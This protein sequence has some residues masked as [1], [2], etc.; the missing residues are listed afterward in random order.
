[1]RCFVASAF[2]C[3]DVDKVYDEVVCRTLRQIGVSAVRVDRVEHN[4]DI[5]DK[6]C[7][8]IRRSDL[9]IADLTYA[10]PS[11]YYE[12]GYAFGLGK[13]VVYIVK[14]DHFRLKP[15]DGTGN[16]RVHFDLQMK[17]IIKWEPI[18]SL[19]VRLK[20]RLLHVIKPLKR[21]AKKV[22]ETQRHVSEFARLSL[23]S[24]LAEV[25]KKAKSLLFVRGFQERQHKE[26]LGL[27]KSPCEA[28]L[29]RVTNGTYQQVFLLARHG[30]TKSQLS[31]FSHYRWFLGPNKEKGVS[32]RRCSCVLLVVT[33]R[34]LRTHTL[35]SALPNAQPLT[36]RVLMISLPETSKDPDR[37]M[38]AVIDQ[39]KSTEDFAERLQDVLA[40]L[41]FV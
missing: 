1:M 25:T 34:P 7:T 21:E 26:G 29:W 28:R 38:L 40:D 22:Q 35:T 10:R 18:D 9:C 24:Q 27:S 2:G 11:V 19:A 41:R 15:D 17:N 3:S 36:D 16:R 31:G 30:V 5:D 20:R 37:Y 23:N 13:P 14:G 8:L 6:I 33:L 39:V 32:F 4:E 12:A